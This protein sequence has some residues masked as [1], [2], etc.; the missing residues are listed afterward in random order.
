MKKRINITIGSRAHKIATATGNVSGYVERVIYEH[1]Q[2][3]RGALHTIARANWNRDELLE[4]LRILEDRVVDT[5]VLHPEEL[6][7]SIDRG[8]TSALTSGKIEAERRQHLAR[9]VSR[10]PN[11]ALALL[12]CLAEHRSG[13]TSWKSMLDEAESSRM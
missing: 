5:T 8:R 9:A 1:W 2:R 11:L 7:A 12:V 3:W 4:V 13:D 6:A 10:D